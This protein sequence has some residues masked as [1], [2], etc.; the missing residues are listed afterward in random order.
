MS[1]KKIVLSVVALVVV[2]YVFYR[3]KKKSDNN[4]T[5]SSFLGLKPSVNPKPS[6]FFKDKKGCEQAGFVMGGWGFT[7]PYCV[8]K[9]QQASIDPKTGQP[10]ISTIT[11]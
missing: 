1:K 6:D 10:K 2:G 9:E 7:A 3:Y 5:I 11:Q 4:L 8:S